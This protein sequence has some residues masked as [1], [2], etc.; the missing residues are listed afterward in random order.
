MSRGTIIAK[1]AAGSTLA[2][3]SYVM[4]DYKTCHPMRKLKGYNVDGA[5]TR[6]HNTLVRKHILP[7]SSFSLK[8]LSRFDGKSQNLIYFSSDGWIWDVTKADSF[9]GNSPYGLWR[10]KDATVSLAK[11]SMDKSDANRT[12]WENLSQQDIESLRSWTDYFA[13][14]YFIK[15]KLKEYAEHHEGRKS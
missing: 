7:T 11:M 13:E 1:V 4:Y 5:I 10:G 2:M 8:D 6:F 14:K 3:A 12:D 9:Q 15:G